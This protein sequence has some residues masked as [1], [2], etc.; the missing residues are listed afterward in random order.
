MEEIPFKVWNKTRTNK[1]IIFCKADVSELLKKG[2]NF[3]I[4]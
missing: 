2:I 1:P 3:I 4:S